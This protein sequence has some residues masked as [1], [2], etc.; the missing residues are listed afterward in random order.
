[1]RNCSN[2]DGSWEVVFDA[3]SGG[4]AELWCNGINNQTNK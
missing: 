3:E 2:I 4:L 1:M